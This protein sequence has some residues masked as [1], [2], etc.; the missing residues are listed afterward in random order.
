MIFVFSANEYFSN[1][2][3]KIRFRFK[4]DE[5]HNNEFPYKCESDVI[6]WLEGKDVTKKMI[7]KVNLI[8]GYP[9]I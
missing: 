8:A 2:K 5:F 1:D 9:A 6:L 7:K 4:E 3:L